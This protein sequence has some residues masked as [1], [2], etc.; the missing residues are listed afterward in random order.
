MFD[1]REGDKRWRG[2]AQSGGDADMKRMKLCYVH[3]LN[4]HKECNH[5]VLQT[6]ADQIKNFLK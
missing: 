6:R 1:K 4:P 2:G 3:V 5:Q